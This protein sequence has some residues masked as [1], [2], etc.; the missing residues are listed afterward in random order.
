MEKKAIQT[1]RSRI[2]TIDKTLVELLSKRM[3]LAYEIGREKGKAGKPVTVPGREEEIYRSLESIE[4]PFLT[5][6]ELKEVFSLIISMGRKA[7]D[8]GA[9]EVKEQRE[10]K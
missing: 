7:G 4:D 3:S 5:P 1:L 2:D 6:E 9:Q 10:Q 8:R